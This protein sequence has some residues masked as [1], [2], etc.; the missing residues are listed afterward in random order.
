MYYT[1]IR[2]FWKHYHSSSWITR[3][4]ELFDCMYTNC[5]GHTQKWIST[6]LI[7]TIQHWSNT[8]WYT[9]VIHIFW[10]LWWVWMIYDQRSPCKTSIC[11]R[12][13]FCLRFGLHCESQLIF[14]HKQMSTIASNI[15]ICG[16]IVYIVRNF[17]S[18]CMPYTILDAVRYY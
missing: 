2:V 10:L 5:R 3:K 7:N 9:L 8:K 4:N 1:A 17:Y 18:I 11:L 16:I 12:T 15:D 13:N 6:T 14:K